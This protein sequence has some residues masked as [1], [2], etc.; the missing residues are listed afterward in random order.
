MFADAKERM[1]EGMQR[2]AD[3]WTKT[4]P[5]FRKSLKAR[6]ILSKHLLAEEKLAS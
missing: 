1:S 5:V 4:V 3:I 6:G 2:A